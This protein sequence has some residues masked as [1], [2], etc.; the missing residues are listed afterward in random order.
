VQPFGVIGLVIGPLVFSLLMSIIGIYKPGML[1][2]RLPIALPA[3]Q[4][5]VS[6]MHFSFIC[7]VHSPPITHIPRSAAHKLQSA[8]LLRMPLST[9]CGAAP[10]P[11]CQRFCRVSSLERRCAP[12]KTPPPLH[13]RPCSWFCL[14]PPHVSPARAP[15]RRLQRVSSP[16]PHLRRGQA[17]RRRAAPPPARRGSPSLQPPAPPWGRN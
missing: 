13:A 12:A 15:L 11:R 4:S 6:R 14:L 17:P 9:A 2:A 8:R 10:P 16:R 3:R 1:K 5:H 7:F